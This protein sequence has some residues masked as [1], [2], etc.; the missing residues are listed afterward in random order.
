MQKYKREF[1]PVSGAW[2]TWYWDAENERF[3]IKNTWSV[4]DVLEANKALA[5]NTID[6]RIGG[7][8]MHHVADIPNGVIVKL[9]REHNL[10]VFTNDPSEQ[11]RLRRLLESPEF[12]YLKTTVKKLWRPT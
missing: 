8:M 7:R 10:D 11:R 12:R 9:K 4:G 6:R 2:E 5:N 3:T 1:N